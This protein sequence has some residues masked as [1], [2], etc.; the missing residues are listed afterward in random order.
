MSGQRGLTPALLRPDWPIPEQVAALMTTRQGGCS[1]A[2]W[3][4]L[5]L[6]DH[7]G[8]DP[9]AVARNRL[10]VQASMYPARPQHTGVAGPLHRPSGI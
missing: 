7:V 3:D 8:D 5:N 10:A 2:P 6:G 1:V 4:S 9:A